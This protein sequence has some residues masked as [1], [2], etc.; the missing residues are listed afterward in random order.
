MNN[1]EQSSCINCL[2]KLKSQVIWRGQVD[3]LRMG[4]VDAVLP[5]CN[6]CLNLSNGK[7]YMNI[8][9]H[10]SIYSTLAKISVAFQLYYAVNVL[11]K[12]PCMFNWYLAMEKC[13]ACSGFHRDRRNRVK[14]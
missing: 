2:H 3:V 12:Y 7:K 8:L 6:P 10:R 1:M 4:Q 9:M 5:T 14:F 13:L 11:M